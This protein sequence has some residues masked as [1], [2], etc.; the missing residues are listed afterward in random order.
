M[1]LHP[2]LLSQSNRLHRSRVSG[3]GPPSWEAPQTWLLPSSALDLL[4]KEIS[5]KISAAQVWLAMQN[6]L[7]VRTLL[8]LHLFCK[9]L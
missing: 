3:V 8:L 9:L 4:S 1:V 6:Q 7:S 2:L 5:Q